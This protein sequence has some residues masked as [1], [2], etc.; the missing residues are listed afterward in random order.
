MLL[1]GER[2]PAATAQQWGLV[3]NVVPRDQLLDEARAIATKIASH[4]SDEA[5]QNTREGMR[6]SLRATLEGQKDITIFSNQLLA[7]LF[8]RMGAT[9][10]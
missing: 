5:I 9:S 4:P 3:T 6:R 7:S 1:T 2:V 8:E 10:S